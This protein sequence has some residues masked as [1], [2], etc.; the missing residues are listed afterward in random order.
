MNK[1]LKIPEL[2]APAGSLESAIY[3]FNAGADAVYFGL[4]HFSARKY[5]VNFDE[6]QYRK[7]LL[8]AKNKNNN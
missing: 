1:N 2:I 8:Y 4:S 5:A 7:L 3:A 6:K